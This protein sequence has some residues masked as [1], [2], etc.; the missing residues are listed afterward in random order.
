MVCSTF[1]SPLSDGLDPRAFASAVGALRTSSLP[2]FSGTESSGDDNDEPADGSSDW[3]GAD[4]SEL[5]LSSVNPSPLAAQAAVIARLRSTEGSA[6][7]AAA[8]V[9]RG[10]QGS[11]PCL[12]DEQTI[13]LEG[14]VTKYSDHLGLPRR[15][16]LVLCD[17]R[18]YAYADAHGY[19]RSPPHSAA[20]GSGRGPESI[21]GRPTMAL[22]L[23]QCALLSVDVTPD[24]ILLVTVHGERKRICFG[25]RRAPRL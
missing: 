9:Q 5:A 14:W 20:T 12:L 13:V 25:A 24:E 2:A 22:D 3:D 11:G 1:F 21:G 4:G 6:H 8:I 23:R 17:H 15:R 19:L 16:W 7:A 10:V 18:V